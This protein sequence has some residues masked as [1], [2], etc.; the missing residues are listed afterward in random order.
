MES[1]A[2]VAMALV[3]GTS[4]VVDVTNM[5]E[6]NSHSTLLSV[7]TTCSCIT[8]LHPCFLE[9][10]SLFAKLVPSSIALH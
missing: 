10:C 2:A 4:S 8:V 9:G 3:R 1:R 6:S 7:S 5:S